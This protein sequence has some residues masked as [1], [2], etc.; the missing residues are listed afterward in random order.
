MNKYNIDFSKYGLEKIEMNLG[1]MQDIDPSFNTIKDNVYYVDEEEL[2]ELIE[3][4]EKFYSA[5]LD[6]RL[7]K[8][9]DLI[10]V[11]PN[12]IHYIKEPSVTL[13]ERALDNGVDLRKI[14]N[15]DGHIIDMAINNKNTGHNY[16][17]IVDK[18]TEEQE[19]K[20]TY[21]FGGPL[22]PLSLK[23]LPLSLFSLLLSYSKKL[24][25]DY[26]CNVNQIT[27]DNCWKYINYILNEFPNYNN[28]LNKDEDVILGINNDKDYMKN[29]PRFIS[30][31][32]CDLFVA[33][34]N[35]HHIS[36]DY[37]DKFIDFTI[38]CS[39]VHR[40]IDKANMKYLG[41]HLYNNPTMLAEYINYIDDELT[42]LAVYRNSK[43][44]ETFGNPS[45]ELIKISK[46]DLNS[47]DLNNS[48]YNLIQICKNP[49]YV[50]ELDKPTEIEMY[51]AFY[52]ETDLL[53]DNKFEGVECYEFY[54]I[55]PD[56]LL[57]KK[58]KFYNDYIYA[59]TFKPSLA[60][61]LD[62]QYI[63]DLD[64]LAY[65]IMLEPSL[66]LKLENPFI[67]YKIIAVLLQ[68]SLYELLQDNSDDLK[69]VLWLSD[70]EMYSNLNLQCKYVDKLGEYVK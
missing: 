54:F 8:P 9:A 43:L 42:Y 18:M 6:K 64:L 34:T 52:L 53:F 2:L 27:L 58:Q 28:I 29:N 39:G 16:Y 21:K 51:L 63:C 67:L 66:I 25:I 14:H 62:I 33:T 44:I 45:D 22:R 68:P 46:G 7:I 15:I 26:N 65:A 69:F 10:E 19:I 40:K 56:L 1:I 47:L 32:L 37:H 61:K 49:K 17:D 60:L 36:K 59:I 55:N 11:N 23:H 70:K 38:S 57:N 31:P 48:C 30:R 20:A 41:I 13:I 35:F 12:I 24:D 5:I 3:K 4:D 50:L